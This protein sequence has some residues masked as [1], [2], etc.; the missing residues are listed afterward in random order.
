M[1]DETLRERFAAWRLLNFDKRR[2]GAGNQG[3]AIQNESKRDSKRACDFS[4]LSSGTRS[5]SR[6]TL[7]TLSAATEISRR[8]IA[9]LSIVPA[10]KPKLVNPR[11]RSLRAERS[12]ERGSSA[13]AAGAARL[14]ILA[15]P[16]RR[17]SLRHVVI[18]ANRSAGVGIV[19]AVTP[20]ISSRRV[21]AP[22]LDVSFNSSRANERHKKREKESL[23]AL[24][25]VARGR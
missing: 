14:F 18:L 1:T 8:K 4:C 21:A 24:V 17:K 2:N 12:R 16:S 9:A 3:I 13:Q 10:G 6:Y 23:I 20:R 22:F 15:K 11:F 19:P 5:R 25:V 7:A